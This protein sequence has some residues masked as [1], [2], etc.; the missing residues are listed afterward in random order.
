MGRDNSTLEELHIKVG[1]RLQLVFTT[2]VRYA[3]A[4][5]MR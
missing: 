1:E 4:W 5:Y 3:I 2:H